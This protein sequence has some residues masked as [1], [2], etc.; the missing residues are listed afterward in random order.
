MQRQRQLKDLEEQIWLVQWYPDDWNLVREVFLSYHRFITQS[1]PSDTY[2]ASRLKQQILLRLRELYEKF[3]VNKKYD[4]LVRFT[5][6]LNQLVDIFSLYLSKAISLNEL[7]AQSEVLVSAIPSVEDYFKY[8]E[9]VRKEI[10][11]KFQSL[12]PQEKNALLLIC[13]FNVPPTMQD[14]V[15]RMGISGGNVRKLVATLSSKGLVYKVGDRYTP[16]KVVKA[17]VE[18]YYKV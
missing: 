4:D 2:E 8:P 16:N 5:T 11:Q 3:V 13:S 14:L 18:S 7:V 6:F 1:F 10:E 12:S 9:Q 17:M 15:S